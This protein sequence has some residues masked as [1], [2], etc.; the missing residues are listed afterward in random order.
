MVF[1]SDEIAVDQPWATPDPDT[2]P[3]NQLNEEYFLICRYRWKLSREV[4]NDGDQRSIE[5]MTNHRKGCTQY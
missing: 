2:E 3:I 5:S 4:L 1:P